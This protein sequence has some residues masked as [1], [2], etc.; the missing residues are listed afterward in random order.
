[1]GKFPSCTYKMHYKKTANKV[2][3]FATT[4]LFTISWL[5]THIMSKQKLTL[6]IDNLKRKFVGNPECTKF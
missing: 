3:M 5:L 6:L 4:G 2:G 1:M